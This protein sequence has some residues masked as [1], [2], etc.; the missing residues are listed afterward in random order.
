LS[1]CYQYIQQ[2][3][4]KNAFVSYMG[5]KIPMESFL[6]EI[7]R[8]AAGLSS[9][10]LVKG[11]V[12]T[13]YLPTCPHSIVAFYACSHLGLVANIVHPVTPLPM[14]KENLQK[15]QSKALLFYDILVRDEKPL[16][17]LGQILIRCSIADYVTWRKPIF[18]LYGNIGKRE[19][20]IKYRSLLKDGVQT[21]SVGTADDIVCYMHSGG[22]SGEAKIVRLTNKAFN[23]VAT[24]LLDMY[25]PVVTGKETSL[26][27][28]PVFHAYGLCVGVH[29]SLALQLSL[30]LV[31]KF[32]LKDVNKCFA[33]HK[34]TMWATV[35]VMVKKMLAY[36]P[37]RGKHIKNIDVIWCGG[38]VVDESLV[39]MTDTVLAR[40]GS[41]ARLMRGYG[42]TETC[43]VC[44][45]NNYQN[46]RKNSCGKPLLNCKA[47]VVDEQGNELP[48]NTLGEIVICTPGLMDGYID[49]GESFDTERGGVK[50]GDIGYIDND[51]FL[52]VVDR[53]KRSIKIAAVNVFPAEIERCIKT[54]PQIAEAC[55]VPYK[56]NQKQYLKA[57]VTL[58]EPMDNDQAT[59]LVV[60][61][62][63]KNLMRYSVPRLVE[64]LPQMPRTKLGKVDFNALQKYPYTQ[65]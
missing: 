20:V 7:D 2:N 25:H 56:Y 55:V 65:D 49:G 45:V 44:A 10:G 41:K 48:A 52:Y 63:S 36:K 27:T 46:Y 4:N 5:H 53:K 60:D 40:Y 34:I 31:P 38:D 24:S 30:A 37:F 9:L 14:L 19:K 57:Y 1:N 18:A 29:T 6:K 54:L 32:N 61:V 39:E 17:E 13:I 50:T 22:T 35:P 26:V 62:C 11:D 42:L 58:T 33:T 43:G 21:P 15:T 3:H 28:L 8:F 23:E 51:G 16:Q 64:V 47:Y 12:V 59:K